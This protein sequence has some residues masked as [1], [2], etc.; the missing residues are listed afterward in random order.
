MCE[1]FDKYLLCEYPK[2]IFPWKFNSTKMSDFS[3]NE[4]KP[5][6]DIKNLQI[7]KV[8]THSV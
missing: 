1:F 4:S 3:V 8:D 5:Y 6:C 7:H 2:I